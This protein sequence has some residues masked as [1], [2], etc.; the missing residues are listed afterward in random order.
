MSL[1]G[2]KKQLNKA[3]QYLSEAIGGVEGTK[4]DEEFHELERRSDLTAR[5]IEQIVERVKEVLQPNPAT[6]ARMAAMT[7][8]ST[9]SG[10]NQPK[11]RNYPQ[12]E[13]MLG[14]TMSR[15]GRDMQT[16]D[17]ASILGDSLVEAG[18]SFRQL[19]E[20]KYSLEAQVS[21]NFLEP[22]AQLSAK[23]IRD[24][25]AYRKKLEG[26]RLDWDCKKRKGG[27]PP[28]EMRQAEQKFEESKVLSEN[29]MYQLLDNEVEQVRKLHAEE[30]ANFGIVELHLVTW[31]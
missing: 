12:T 24:M 11:Q 14:D 22:L 8:F 7:T 18:E 15:F 27:V 2:L 4:L 6:R 21:Q 28:D 13:G 31:S 26:R 16:A 30:C 3:N 17:T 9:V 19:A 29:S 25:Y 5:A 23:E 10:A 1:A 20:V